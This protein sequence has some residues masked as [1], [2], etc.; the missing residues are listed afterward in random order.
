MYRGK[1]ITYLQANANK[2]ASIGNVSFTY[3]ADGMR[4]SKTVN[5]V[6]HYY[7]YDGIQLVKE[8]WGN[9]VMIFLYDATGSPVGMQYRNSTYA[10]G[11]WDI[12]YYEKNLQGDI[13]AIYNATGTKLVSYDYDAWGRITSITDAMAIHCSKI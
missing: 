4:R 11:V 8:E 7:T 3:D 12:Y 2:I 5:G 9:N 1:Q 6:T 10:A 13:V